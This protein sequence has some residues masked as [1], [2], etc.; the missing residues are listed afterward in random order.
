MNGVTRVYH[1]Y[2]YLAA[3]LLAGAAV[4]LLALFPAVVV[5]ALYLPLWFVTLVTLMYAGVGPTILAQ[6][7]IF[8]AVA[9]LG[10]PPGG[11]M[12]LRIGIFAL[13][14]VLGW[15]LQWERN[16]SSRRELALLE[17]ETRYRHILEQ[18][19]DGIVLAKPDGQLVLVNQRICEMMGYSEAELLQLSLSSLYEPSELARAPLGWDELLRSSMVIRE[20]RLRRKD[21]STYIAELSVRRTA[22]GL[23]QAIVR[24]ITER[25]RSEAAIRAERDLL[26]GVLTTSVAGIVVVNPIGQVIFLNPS[27]EA[28]LGISRAQ[29]GSATELPPSWR[30]VNLDGTALLPEARPARR[31]V[32]TGEPVNDARFAVLRPDGRRVVVSVNAA[33]LRN[34][35]GVITAIVL[36]LSD[37]T[38][39]YVVQQAL[40]EREEQLHR[41]TA[42]VPGVVYQYVV[43]PGEE[44]R[45]VFVSE[46]ARELLGATAEEILSDAGKAWTLMEPED[47]LAMSTQF[48]RSAATLEPWSFDFRVRGPGERIRWLRDIATADSAASPGLVVWNGVIVDITERKRL[49]QE[50]LQSQKMDSLGRLA[51]GVAHDFNNLLTVI[52]G[53]ADVLSRELSDGDPHFAEVREIRRAADRATALTRQLLALSRRQVL[54]PREVDLNALVQEMEQMLRRVIGENISIVTLRGPDV[55]MVRADPGQLEQVLLNLA[56]NAR[57]AMPSGGTLT[58]ATTR[59]RLSGDEPAARGIPPGDYVVLRVSDTGIG[60]DGETQAKIFEPFFTTKPLGEGTGLGLST[61]YGIVQQSSGAIAVESEVGEGSTFRIFL[62][63]LAEG[64]V[65]TIDTPP[66]GIHRPAGQRRR[67]TVLLVEDDDGVRQL[68]RRILEDFGF[69]VLEARNGT[70]A[71]AHLDAGSPR[72]DAVVSDVVMPGMGGRELVGRLR[73]RRPDLPVL[74]LSGYTGDEVSDDVRGQLHQAFMQKPFSPDA[75]A[76]AL[77]ELLAEGTPVAPSS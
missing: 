27:A 69:A 26:D 5:N 29:L 9:I 53:Y 59:V 8:A 20:R 21:G 76:A 23:A 15:R 16:A 66:G 64:A 37:I 36:S 41:I 45:F 35:G 11:G 34:A 33:P 68:T 44:E 3:L 63:R 13:A 18:A 6:V 61:V 71:L 58:I 60:I 25:R 47:R 74:F 67:N 17:S 43:G 19:S 77:E 22:D 12:L 56:V 10:P 1:R 40:R 75:L 62:P 38:D 49:E 50:L 24:D 65:A 57:D 42:A 32:R 14:D 55:G 7:I 52:R 54:M 72:I 70:E 39:Q 31:V 73:L 51:G 2:R 46:G 48:G 4:L 30:L 28:V